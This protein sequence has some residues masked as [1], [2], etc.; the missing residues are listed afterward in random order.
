M[1]KW[2]I[3]SPTPSLFPNFIQHLLTRIWWLKPCNTNSSK[4]SLSITTRT[5]WINYM[6]VKIPPLEET[7][8]T[9]IND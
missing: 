1:P 2:E 5:N 3:H 6:V 9:K 4:I 8:R 7:L